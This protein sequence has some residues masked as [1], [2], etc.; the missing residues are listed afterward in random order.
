MAT[1]LAVRLEGNWIDIRV[2]I[3]AVVLPLASTALPS[4]LCPESPLPKHAIEAC[5]APTVQA[6]QICSAAALPCGN[7]ATVVEPYCGQIAAPAN[8]KAYV[9]VEQVAHVS[10]AVA[11]K[12]V[13]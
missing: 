12:A 4:P 1:A 2:V 8:G 5:A 3:S 11:P 9:F 7:Q 6:T 10:T 13:E